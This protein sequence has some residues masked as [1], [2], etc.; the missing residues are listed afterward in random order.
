VYR[1]KKPPRRKAD[2]KPLWNSTPLC[3]KLRMLWGICNC[4]EFFI[5]LRKESPIEACRDLRPIFYLIM[6]CSSIVYAWF[7]E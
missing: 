6:A 4:I 7:I 2:G 3:S 1:T 5:Y